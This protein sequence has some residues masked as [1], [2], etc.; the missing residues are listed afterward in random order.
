MTSSSPPTTSTH[1]WSHR[2][3]EHGW[4]DNTKGGFGTLD[5][6]DPADDER[7]LRSL[8]AR[9]TASTE[10]LPLLGNPRS[11]LPPHSIPIASSL[12][13]RFSSIHF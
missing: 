6:D 9:A 13:G 5:T 4:P 11:G 7:P 12:V 10:L 8:D 1:L 2:S 3:N